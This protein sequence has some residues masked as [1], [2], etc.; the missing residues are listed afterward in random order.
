MLAPSPLARRLVD[1]LEADGTPFVAAFVRAMLDGRLPSTTLLAVCP[2]SEAVTR[3]TLRVAE[4]A[5]M[6]ALF[7]ATLNQVDAI[8]SGGYTGWTPASFAEFVTGEAERLGVTMPIGLGLDH[9]GP[10]RTAAHVGLDESEA[11]AAAKRSL[12]ACLDAGYA[13]L[14]LDATTDPDG[15]SVPPD[16]IVARTLALIV[17]A[18]SYRT[19]QGL[20][21]V[22]YEVGTEDIAGGLAEEAAFVRFLADLHAGLRVRGL[23]HAAP[24]FVVGQVGTLLT[25]DRF[26]AEKA[27]ALTQQA[28][29]FGALVK[30]HDTDF[31]AQPSAYPTSGMGGA[32]IGPVCTV[33]E[34]DALC[35]LADQARARG[36]RSEIERVIRDAVRDDGHWRTWLGPD[37]QTASLDDLAEDR[38]RWLVA[39][40]ARYVWT[41]PEVVAARSDLYAAVADLAPDAVVGAHIDAVLERY[42]AAFNLA[43]LS[44]RLVGL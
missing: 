41:H 5:R 3:A 43:G 10:W 40:G 35:D 9:G 7:A 13:L 16:T 4:R 18:E 42:V 28:R 6:P 23:L 17:H 20:P 21:P 25:T 22:A 27:A 11:M 8:P 39:T 32:N 30:G 33:A 36:Q 12:D 15:T 34:Y 29:R 14:H 2:N 38:Q 44:E 31:V 19:A 26:D 24:C 1:R 37:E